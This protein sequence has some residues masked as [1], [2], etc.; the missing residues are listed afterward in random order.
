MKKLFTI[1]SLAVALV[2][3]SE[4][5]KAQTI[6]DTSDPF[7]LSID[8]TTP[9]ISINLQGS[10]DVSFVYG[11]ADSYNKPNVVSKPGH[12]SVISNRPYEVIAQAGA[13]T[14]S[15]SDE[16]ALSVVQMTAT[17]VTGD[18]TNET[19]TTVPL[20]D[21]AGQALVVSAPATTNSV[22]NIDF[23]IPSA[24]PLLDVAAEVYT[25]SVTYTATQL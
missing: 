22:Y 20:T 25:T 1:C 7:L 14:S 5:A 8:V 15:S 12:F 9:V 3:F 17:R 4:S 10:A 24:A 16:L 21:G 2:S 18:G 19:S 23:S 11:D 6:S 13:F